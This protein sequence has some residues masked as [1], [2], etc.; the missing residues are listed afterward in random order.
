MSC[1]H[2]LFQQ[3][4]VPEMDR[5][6]IPHGL[7]GLR[8]VVFGNIEKIYQFHVRH[9]LPNLAKYT[10]VPSKVGGCFLKYVSTS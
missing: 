5:E 10:S 6:D 9:F 8:S 1:I 2:N 7:R 3:N 4:Y